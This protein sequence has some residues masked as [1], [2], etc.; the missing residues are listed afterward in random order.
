[1]VAAPPAKPQIRDQRDVVVP[2]N[3]LAAREAVRARLDD[4]TPVRVRLA[5]RPAID[6]HV[7]EAAPDE[8]QRDD[9]DVRRGRGRQRFERGEQPSSTVPLPTG[10]VE[11]TRLA[12]N[13]KNPTCF[14]NLSRSR[15]S[16]AAAGPRASTT[17]SSA[18]SS[19]RPSPAR[20]TRS[21][22]P[23]SWR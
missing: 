18:T 6:A 5:R 2:A 13:A 7:R 17:R 11:L 1:A 9:E 22:T 10:G 23:T 12:V 8:A 3:R 21:S 15:W 16:P 20:M 4:G 19:S 14:A